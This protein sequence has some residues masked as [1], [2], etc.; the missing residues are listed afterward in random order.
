[1][2]PVQKGLSRKKKQSI[3]HP[4]IPLVTFPAPHGKDLLLPNAPTSGAE[5]GE[6]QEENDNCVGSSLP[7]DQ[8]I[9]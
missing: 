9:D 3:Q 8:N 1:M 2:T 7:N 5:S 6:E 4:N